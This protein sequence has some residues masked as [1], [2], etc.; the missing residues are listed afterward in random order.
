[1]T[2]ADKRKSFYEDVVQIGKKEDSG[3]EKAI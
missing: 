3:V 2:A 1:V